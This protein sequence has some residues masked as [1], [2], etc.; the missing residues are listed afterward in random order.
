MQNSSKY[1]GRASISRK[2]CTG[3]TPHCKNPFTAQ[4]AANVSI[5]LF[6]GYIFIGSLAYIRYFD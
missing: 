6:F 4:T 3:K 5:A 2:Y 1:L